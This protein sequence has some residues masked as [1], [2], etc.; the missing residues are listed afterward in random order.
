MAEFVFKREEEV[1]K[2]KVDLHVH[3][4]NDLVEIVAGRK[5]LIPPRELIDMAVEQ[6]FDAIA[7]THHGV[8]YHEHELAAYAR[9]KGLL[10]IPGVETYI[11]KKHVLLINFST[12]K[13][14]LTFQDLAKYKTDEVLVIAPHPFYLVPECLGRNLIRHRHCFDAVEYCHYYY[15]WF[16]LNRKALRIARRLNLPMIGNSDAHRHFQFGK[17]YSYVYAEE[18]TTPAII[19]AIK[20]GKVEYV[21][22]PLTLR[23]FLRETLWLLE[24]LPY[25]INITLSK[26][27]LR[28]SQPL[29]MRKFATPKVPYSALKIRK[30]A[31]EHNAEYLASDESILQHSNKADL[32]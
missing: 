8:Q 1:V 27:A 21:S 32:K 26:I 9:Q 15:K 25:I 7:I 12:K 31:L 22:H 23:E 11:Q 2:L 29:L 14:I 5:N 13:H 17:T 19:Q 6:K 24:K 10:L 18:K 16:N 30:N 3:T 20:Q 4:A 28:T